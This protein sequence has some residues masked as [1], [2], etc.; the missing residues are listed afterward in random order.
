MRR[1]DKDACEAPE[2]F[3]PRIPWPEPWTAAR[4]I[5]ALERFA[6]PARAQRLRE[7]IERRLGNVTVVL[8]SPHDPH[9]GAAV[10]R[11]ADAFGLPE[12]HVVPNDESFRI[13][14]TVARGAQR[15]VDALVH[16][17]PASAINGLRARGFELIGT[18]P[19][20]ELLPED[21][22]A[23]PRLALILGNEHAG[24]REE[25]RRACSRSVRI[26]MRGFVESLN[27]SVA[28]A[29]LL[30]AATEG[31]PGDLDAE[32]RDL[33]YAKFLFRSVPR[34][35]TILQAF[36]AEHGAEPRVIPPSVPERSSGRSY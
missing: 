8:D 2:L 3:G 6:I 23:I 13:G 17:T 27:M 24:L 11:T 29:I 26:P 4:V 33:L 31:R 28:A 21:L 15:W 36:G 9:N 1:F 34:A 25:F 16:E 35:L 12:I 20:G 14:R 5:D 10:L 32:A 22:R 7:G 19:E 18:H 30:A